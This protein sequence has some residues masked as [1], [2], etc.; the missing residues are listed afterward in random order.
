M[1]HDVVFDHV[2]FGYGAGEDGRA[3]EKVLTDVSFTAKE[4]EVTALVGPSGSGKSTVSRLAARFWD[5]TE[6]TV[7]VGGVDVASV[8]PE[9]LLRDYAIVFQDVSAL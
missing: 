1:G 8:D 5:A 2:A 3:G 6:G 7:T 9:V 4:G